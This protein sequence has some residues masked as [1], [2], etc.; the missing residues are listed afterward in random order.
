MS[1]NRNRVY[2]PFNFPGSSQGSRTLL[3]G[4]RKC[5]CDYIITGFYEYPDTDL[6]PASFIYKGDLLGKGKWYTLNFP[7]SQGNT[8]TSTN[9][10]GPDVYHCSPSD[11]SYNDPYYQF[12]GNYTILEQT[13]TF[14]CLYQGPLSGGGKWTKI[15]PTPLSTEPILNTICHSVMD[16]V[17]VGNYDT[18]LIQGRA[19]LYQI[20][21]GRYYDIR[22]PGAI[23]ITAYGVWKNCNGS[24]TIAGGNVNESDPLREVGY[25]VDWFEESFENWSFYQF[26]QSA[27]ALV[28][29]FDGISY[30][31]S[32]YSLTGDYVIPGVGAQAFYAQVKRQ[33]RNQFSKRAYWETLTIEGA[34][35]VSGNSVSGNVV[36]GV[37]DNISDLTTVNGY[38]SFLLI[39]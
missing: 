30:N 35:G 8:V 39:K 16:D 7:S 10:Y 13:G 19:F 29:H 17:V 32:I 12:V 36:I 33:K 23:S 18:L 9:L 2:L 24:Y 11:C 22:S 34:N 27:L 20:S 31:D 4:I 38:V 15:V 26:N 25:L 14:G 1:C 5:K 21:T 6:I 37:Y 28:T 3:T